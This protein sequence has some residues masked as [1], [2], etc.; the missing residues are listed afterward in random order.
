MLNSNA[1]HKS[2]IPLREQN[3][4]I[5]SCRQ[6]LTVLVA[7]ALLHQSNTHTH[8]IT[9]SSSVLNKHFIGIVWK[10]DGS[11]KNFTK[12]ILTLETP[13]PPHFFRLDSQ[14]KFKRQFHLQVLCEW[15]WSV[16]LEQF[17]NPFRP[18]DQT[19][20]CTANKKWVPKLR[21]STNVARLP[22]W[23]NTTS[24]QNRKPT[25]YGAERSNKRTLLFIH[26]CVVVVHNC[27]L[28]YILF[29]NGCHLLVKCAE[30]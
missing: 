21:V 23:E 14:M 18:I 11:K 3:K 30:K 27:N 2:E 6:H 16:H 7:Y 17:K 22:N 26:Y 24:S 28:K 9:W 8:N 29:V 15:K 25:L 4:W 13:P 1:V 20:P 5:Q 12:L 19:I 10:I